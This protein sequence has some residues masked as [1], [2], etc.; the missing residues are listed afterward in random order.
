MSIEKIIKEAI[1][2]C[3]KNFVEPKLI[4]L[5][6]E[7]FKELEHSLSVKMG[8]DYADGERKKLTYYEGIEVDCRLPEADEVANKLWTFSFICSYNEYENSL[9]GGLKLV[10]KGRYFNLRSL[11]EIVETTEDVLAQ[12]NKLRKEWDRPLEY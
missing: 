7:D 12:Q 8:I 9:G 5:T 3:K 2:H 11:E 6:D 4:N 10:K 1:C